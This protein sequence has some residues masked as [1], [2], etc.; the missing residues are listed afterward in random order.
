MNERQGVAVNRD[1]EIAETFV[2]AENLLPDRNGAVPLYP[3][4]APDTH[5]PMWRCP[6]C[7]ESGPTM[8]DLWRLYK[9]RE[10]LI[11]EKFEL[12][13]HNSEE[14]SAYMEGVQE[15]NREISRLTWAIPSEV[16]SWI[17]RQVEPRFWDESDLNP[18]NYRQTSQE[19][20]SP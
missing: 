3:D 17:R 14:Y 13:D 10:R 9:R 6:C 20:E 11:Q 18:V 19:G 5:L 4:H 12:D 7:G 15:I 16:S 1:Q 2:S 8:K